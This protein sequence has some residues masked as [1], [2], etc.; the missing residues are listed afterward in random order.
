MGTHF[1]MEFLISYHCDGHTWGQCCAVAS[2]IRGS[3]FQILAD[4]DLSRFQIA[5]N[6]LLRH[7]TQ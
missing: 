5:D 1:Q 4:V 6:L 3:D 2:L 7:M